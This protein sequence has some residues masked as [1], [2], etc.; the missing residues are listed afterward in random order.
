MKLKRVDSETF[1]KNPHQY[2]LVSGK[3][4]GAPT[5]PYGNQYQ[6]VG[7]DLVNRS[8]VRLTKSIFK[9]LIKA[10]KT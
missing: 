1:H 4:K 6:W 3:T 8:F 2:K 7:Y 5:C 10:K 9:K